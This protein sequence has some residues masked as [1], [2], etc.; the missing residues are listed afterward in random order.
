MLS[1]LPSLPKNA[2]VAVAGSGIAGLSFSYFLSK[3]RPDVKITLY[4]A[5]NRS[6][7]WI[8][9]WETKDKTGKPVMIE[10]GPRT[11]RGVSDG[12]VMMVD[13]MKD[14]NSIDKVH[15]IEKSSD[16]DK[17]FLVD[18]NDKLV[19]VPNSVMSGIQF[20]MSGLGKGIIPAMLGEFWR[21][22]NSNPNQDETV[23]S[24]LKRRMGND[25]LGKNVFSAIY[26][27][28]YADDINTLSA[29][30]VVHKMVYNEKMFGSNVNAL[31]HKFKTRKE[32][33][34]QSK[35]LSPVLDKYCETLKKPE[36][37]IANLST[38]L[39][40]YP[41]MGFQ[42]GL[43]TFCKTIYRGLENSPNVSIY[44]GK[45]ITK[46]SKDKDKR[47]TKVSVEV[48]HGEDIEEFDHVRL[49][50]VPHNLGR[51]VRDQ[52]A[53]IAKR[54][55]TI[56][57]NT[58]VLVNFY[59]HDKDII[60]IK[61]RGFGYLVPESNPNKEKLLG[62]IFDSVIEQNLKRFED[63]KVM[64]PADKQNYTKLTAMV[65]G[66]MLNDKK[67]GEPIIPED[68]QVIDNIKM[69]LQKHLGMS[70]NDLDRG[71][72]QVTVAN[73]CL[74]RFGAGYMQWQGKMETD[75]LELYNSKVSLGGMGFAIGP[76][77]PDVFVDGFQDALK[78]R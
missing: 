48:N 57:A 2:K 1:P 16:A 53:D 21:K 22:P 62:V 52:N 8:N 20:I 69:S 63:S 28:I 11:L 40:K 43:E 71:L 12:T 47:K 26:R 25:Y 60:P 39:K 46:I 9:S 6:S 24:L 14:L 54:L 51:V 15:Y 50:N 49:T 38:T 33:K 36:S 41:M 68:T 13:A 29:Q 78:L 30:K 58:V 64:V 61:N 23:A 10:R 37:S 76:G 17:K 55:E 18:P 34:S 59:L 74:P 75:L 7:G 66:Y 56:T 67:T 44:L 5:A 4:E 35:H 32:R 31:W 70:L 72:W 27:G 42:G 65:G 19:Q 45:E 73:K 77:I 3:L